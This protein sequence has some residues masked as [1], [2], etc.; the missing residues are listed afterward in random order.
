MYKLKKN[1]HQ[2]IFTSILRKYYWNIPKKSSIAVDSPIDRRICINNSIKMNDIF[3]NY[4]TR[5]ATFSHSNWV[6]RIRKSESCC[7]LYSAYHKWSSE[8]VW[9]L[10]ATLTSFQSGIYFLIYFHTYAIL[11]RPVNDADLVE[12]RPFCI[13]SKK[14]KFQFHINRQ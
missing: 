13:N 1:E 2:L 10:N 8:N 5:T 7:S 9:S 11:F 3:K 14:A 4:R 6:N 12:I